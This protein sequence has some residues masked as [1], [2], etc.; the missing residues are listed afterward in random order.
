MPAAS[1][2]RVYCPKCGSFDVRYSYRQ[3]TWDL[4]LDVLFSMD[5]YRCRACRSRFHKYDRA[6]DG[7]G[8]DREE[9]DDR[10]EDAQSDVSPSDPAR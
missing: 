2:E 3:S 1:Q 8:R 5:A 10:Q 6:G 4:M 9:A 7:R